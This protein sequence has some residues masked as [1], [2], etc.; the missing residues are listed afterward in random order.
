ML[1]DYLMWDMG[2]HAFHKCLWARGQRREMDLSSG[3]I[4]V[5]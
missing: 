4:Q 1:W 5:L 2:I 3:M